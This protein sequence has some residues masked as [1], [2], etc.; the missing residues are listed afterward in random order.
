MRLKEISS[1]MCDE[2]WPDIK[3]KPIQKPN[4]LACAECE[5][6]CLGGV[7]LLKK[8]KDEEFQALLCGGDCN[9]CRQPCNLRRIAIMRKIKPPVIR[10]RAKPK[11]KTWLEIAMRPYTERHGECVNGN[12]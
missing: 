5:S 11:C 4:L 1:I 10:Q 7:E 6:M 3:G 2:G 8:I 12:R 9:A